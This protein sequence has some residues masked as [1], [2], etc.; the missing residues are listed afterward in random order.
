MTTTQNTPT[1]A[2]HDFAAGQNHLVTSCPQHGTKEVSDFASFK[3]Y[4]ATARECDRGYIWHAD[5]QI[6]SLPFHDD[7]HAAGGHSCWRCCER[8]VIDPYGVLDF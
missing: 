8:M 3:E 6:E 2:F 5:G 4:V 7:F 1:P